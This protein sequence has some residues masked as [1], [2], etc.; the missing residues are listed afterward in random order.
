VPTSSETHPNRLRLEAFYEAFSKRDFDTM[1]KIY[2]SDAVFYDPVFQHL[3]ALDVRKMWKMLCLRGKDLTVKYQVIS[4]D[5]HIGKAQWDAYY[6][7]SGTGKKVVNRVKS[8]FV[9]K[10]GLVVNHRDAFDLYG[11][12]KQA[13]GLVG[14]LLGW[15]PWF[16]SKIRQRAKSSLDQFTG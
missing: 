16:K 2:A 11:W 4:A 14:W 6:T 7:F 10:D 5:D 13:F 3:N 12:C 15:T 8:E 9:F 1:N